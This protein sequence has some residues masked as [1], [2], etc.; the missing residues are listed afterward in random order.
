MR[1]DFS[2]KIRY[3]KI[4]V[5]DLKFYMRFAETY[6]ARSRLGMPQDQ[7]ILHMGGIHGDNKR[8]QFQEEGLWD[9]SFTVNKDNRQSGVIPLWQ[10]L[11][12]KP[13]E[14]GIFSLYS[15][16]M[17][18]MILTFISFMILMTHLQSHDVARRWRM[19]SFRSVARRFRFPLNQ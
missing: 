19:L 8:I 14:A 9:G 12:T 1:V 4:Q 13:S 3:Y 7:I 11:A 10:W 18:L 6:R 16:S 2:K 15:K 17:W 5:G